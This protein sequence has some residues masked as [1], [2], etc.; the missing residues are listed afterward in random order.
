MNSIRPLAN[1]PVLHSVDQRLLNSV[2]M[3]LSGFKRDPAEIMT[4]VTNTMLSCC[5]KVHLRLVPKGL[6]NCRTPG[7]WGPNVS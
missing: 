6:H 4:K 3:Y 7:I 1:R 5:H 2:S